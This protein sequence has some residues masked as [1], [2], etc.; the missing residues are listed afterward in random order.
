MNNKELLIKNKHKL[1]DEE[2]KECCRQSIINAK[3]LYND[4]VHLK[5]ERRY[6][7][8]IALGIISL[9]E[10]GK[11]FMFYNAHNQ[12]NIDWGKFWNDVYN[13]RKKQDAFFESAREHLPRE[14]S[15]NIDLLKQLGLEEDKQDLLY[16]TYDYSGKK[17]RS[18]DCYINKET[19]ADS[20]LR[21]IKGVLALEGLSNWQ[22]E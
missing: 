19:N 11:A 12:G 17:V 16:V 9:E 4:A 8:A 20:I 10:L 1:S 21:L 2:M 15:S 3:R 18:P 13:H 5:E 14:S 6:E 7:S 22:G